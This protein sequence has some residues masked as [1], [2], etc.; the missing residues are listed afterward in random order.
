MTL[1]SKI[2]VQKGTLNVLLLLR[3]MLLGQGM[4][5]FT[6]SILNE[7]KL[8]LLGESNFGAVEYIFFNYCAN[9]DF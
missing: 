5:V 8:K 7:E 3:P 4:D 2:L 1:V 9:L 6:I